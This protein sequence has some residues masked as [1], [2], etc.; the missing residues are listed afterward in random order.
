MSTHRFRTLLA[1]MTNAMLIH[2]YNPDKLLASVIASIPKDK[3]ASLNNSD[4]YRGIS[5]C[6]ALCKVIDYVFIDKYSTN[7]NSSNMQF[8]FKSSHDTTLCT[9]MLKETVSYHLNRGSD[10]YACMLDASKA[11][12]KVHF[13]KLFKLLVDRNIPSIVIRLLL[14]N[15]TRQKIVTSWN[16]AK[17]RE[18]SAA[19]GVRQGGVLSPIL[20]NIYFDEMLTRLKRKGIGCKVGIYFLGAL[21]YADDVIL[22]CPSRKGL[23]EMLDICELFGDEYHVGYNATKTKCIKFSNIAV[24]EQYCVKLNDVILKWVRSV[25]HLGNEIDCSLRDKCDVDAK[26]YTFIGSVNKLLHIF[27]CLQ[28]HVLVKLFQNYCCSFYG[29]VLWKQ[30]DS[31]IHDICIEWNKALRKVWR[32]PNTAHTAMLGPLNNQCHISDQLSMRFMKFYDRMHRCDNDLVNFMANV[33]KHNHNG[34]IKNNIMYIKWKYDI[35]LTKMDVSSCIK[36]VK[37]MHASNPLVQLLD[38]LIHV[39]DSSKYIDGFNHDE[40][41]NLI[42]DVSTF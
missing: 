34:F 35:D 42:C 18:F 38:E 36:R 14:D 11:F 37:Q 4:N 25:N 16:G 32:L 6:C 23:Q 31:A 30:N 21:A 40:V 2:G 15:Y 9:A 10:V 39:R 1:L 5:L 7:L 13:G 41:L 19:N 20:F 3:R 33:A 24:D 17:S 26:K 29:S 27:G 12:D 28:S 22:L 8:A